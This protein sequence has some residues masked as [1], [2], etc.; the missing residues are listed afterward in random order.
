MRSPLPRSRTTWRA[1]A[2]AASKR[3]GLASLAF[4]DAEASSSSTTEPEVTLATGMAGRASPNTSAARM[5]SC[6]S[7]NRLRLSFCQ[8]ALACR[9]RSSACHSMVEETST[10]RRRS[11]SM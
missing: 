7:S 10:L 3:E 9:S 2:S 8:G 5:S 11:L 4:I 1:I 6:S